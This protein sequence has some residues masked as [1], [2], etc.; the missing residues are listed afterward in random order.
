DF[1]VAAP[2]FFSEFELD[3][4]AANLKYL[5]KVIEISGSVRSFSKDEEGIVSI[6][7]GTDNELSGVICQLDQLTTHKRTT[8]ESGEAVKFKGICTGMLMD[9][10]LVRCV[11]IP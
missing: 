9:V 10:V 2:A 8:F 6:T 4:T 1:V 11:E 3:E 5:D 7:L